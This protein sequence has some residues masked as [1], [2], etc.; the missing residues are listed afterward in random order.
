MYRILMA[1][2][3]AACSSPR[4]VEG[5]WT[6]ELMD[7]QLDGVAE[8][9]ADGISV[10]LT[11]IGTSGTL[12]MPGLLEVPAE[13][14]DCDV[15]TVVLEPLGKVERLQASFDLDCESL[16]G[17]VVFDLAVSGAEDAGR[18]EGAVEISADGDVISCATVLEHEPVEL[19]D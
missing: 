4:S 15:S 2:S 3:L 9:D 6:G 1:L 18:A 5:V 17:T 14:A 16:V 10:L 12:T 8:E 13:Y 11:L 19:F 7:C